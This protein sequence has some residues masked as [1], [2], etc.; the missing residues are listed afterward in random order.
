[1]ENKI[2]YAAPD[3]TSPSTVAAIVKGERGA[4]RAKDGPAAKSKEKTMKEGSSEG[5]DRSEYQEIGSN[6]VVLILHA[7]AA[8]RRDTTARQ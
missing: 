1:M 5:K 4:A 7:G 8:T 6:A 2:V 3:P